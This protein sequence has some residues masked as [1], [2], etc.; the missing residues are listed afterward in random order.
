MS[1]DK[2]DLYVVARFLDILYRTGVPMKKTRLQLHIGL[3][4]PRFMEYLEWMLQHD[5]A[6][7][8]DDQHGE[9]A[10]V[11]SPKGIESYHRLVEWIKDMLQD[12]KI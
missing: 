9:N 12:L 8:I 11:L 10:I 5:L 7:R 3:N 2:P 4:Y 1:L 6:R